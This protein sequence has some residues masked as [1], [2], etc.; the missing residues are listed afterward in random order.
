MKRLLAAGTFSLLAGLFSLLLLA[1][2]FYS[3]RSGGSP[4]DMG[5]STHEAAPPDSTPVVTTRAGSSSPPSQL[6]REPHRPGPP[7]TAFSPFP[8]TVR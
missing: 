3:C 5:T 1:A 4:H 8:N 6:G 7:L 2:I